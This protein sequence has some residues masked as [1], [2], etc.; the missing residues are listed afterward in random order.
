MWNGSYGTTSRGSFYGGKSSMKLTLN[1]ENDTFA[2]VGHQVAYL[3]Y[4]PYVK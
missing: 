1:M 3:M 4:I 2:S